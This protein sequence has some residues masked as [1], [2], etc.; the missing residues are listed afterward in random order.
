MIYSASGEGFII[1]LINPKIALFFI[2]VWVTRQHLIEV[3]KRILGLDTS[4]NDTDEPM[5]YRWAVVGLIASFLILA[6]FTRLA[7]MQVWIAAIFFGL[8]FMLSFADSGN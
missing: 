8:Y 7:G 5:P 2:A 4:L 6:I 3:G 1:S